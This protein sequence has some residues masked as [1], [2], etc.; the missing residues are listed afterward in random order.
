MVKYTL[1]EHA[2]E[3]LTKRRVASEWLERTLANPQFVQ[4]DPTDSSLEHRLA[5]IPEH[6][7]RVL[8]VI[9]NT[10]VTPLRVVTLYFD[11]NMKGRL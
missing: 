5:V 8:R 10:S 1:T 3:A 4:P 2:K 7:D 6:G 9:V 11:R